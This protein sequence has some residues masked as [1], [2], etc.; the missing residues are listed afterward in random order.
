MYK[1]VSSLVL[2]SDTV[3]H[4][5]KTDCQCEEFVKRLEREL[6]SNEGAEGVKM[7]IGIYELDKQ[8]K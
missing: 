3:C 5:I 7:G 4:N 2:W 8:N 1:Q 6:L